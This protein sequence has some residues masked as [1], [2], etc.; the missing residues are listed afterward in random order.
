M[1]LRTRSI[2][3]DVLAPFFTEGDEGVDINGEQDW[4]YAEHLISTGQA[5]LPDIAEPA[6]EEITA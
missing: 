4:W 2:A 3:G 6:F 1:A 5:R